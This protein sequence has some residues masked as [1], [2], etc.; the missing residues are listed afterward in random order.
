MEIL[1]RVIIAAIFIPILLAIL[2]LGGW[3]LK[4]L[5]AIIASVQLW[6]IKNLFENKNVRISW[7]IFPCGLMLFFAN[8]Y[9]QLAVLIVLM[10]SFIIFIGIDLFGNKLHGSISRISYSIFSLIYIALLLSLAYKITDFAEGNFLLIS[11][12]ITIWIT[13]SAA[14][15]LGMSLG[16]HRGIFAASPNKSIEGFIAGIV[17]AFIAAYALGTIF[18]FVTFEIISLA[19]AAGIFGQF[20]DLFESILKRDAQVKDSSSILPGHG[21]ILDRFDSLL[22][23]APV[24]Y[25]L[26]SLGG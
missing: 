15:F 4:I 21:G 3:Y 7:M 9:G 14:Y 17:F 5:L 10:A 2:Y 20:G 18:E 22:F 26:L 16:K 23:A 8:L 1:K 11:L 25:F 12:V 19:L 6:E 24:L 13:D